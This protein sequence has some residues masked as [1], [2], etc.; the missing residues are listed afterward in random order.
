MFAFRCRSCGKVHEGIPAF[1][2]DYPDHYLDVPEAE[3]QRR[4]YLTSD[5]CVIDDAFFFVRGCLEVPVSGESEALSWGVWTSL[6]EKNFLHFQELSGVARRSDHGPFFG[7][8]STDIHIY[9]GTLNLKTMVHLRDDGIR[10][11]VELEPTDHALAIEQRQG[12]TLDRV[13]EIYERMVHPDG[14]SD[15]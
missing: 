6:S 14:D 15:Q 5:T 8:L 3:R 11:Y 12:I 7:W 1:G 13:A 4:C 2:W 9:P 10:P